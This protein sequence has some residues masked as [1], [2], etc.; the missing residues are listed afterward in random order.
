MTWHGIEIKRGDRFQI[1]DN[2]R[3]HIVDLCDEKEH[4]VRF[5]C[6]LLVPVGGLEHG[7][8]LLPCKNCLSAYRRMI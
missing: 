5:M 4:A 1:G 8:G 6:R 3:A 2:T 7:R